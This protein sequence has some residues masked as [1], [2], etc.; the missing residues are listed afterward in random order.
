MYTA[1]K[2]SRE[3]IECIVKLSVSGFFFFQKVVFMTRCDS[4]QRAEIR[5]FSLEHCS[6]S[7]ELHN[8]LA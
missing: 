5:V 7:T 1:I 8:I 3:T 4:L 2:L 6:I